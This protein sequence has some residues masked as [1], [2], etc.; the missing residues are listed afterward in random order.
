MFSG[1]K[2]LRRVFS[3]RG[4]FEPNHMKT[5]NK[6]RWRRVNFQLDLVPSDYLGLYCPHTF[7]MQVQR[8]LCRYA[9]LHGATGLYYK[10]YGT[11]GWARMIVHPFLSFQLMAL[12][13]FFPKYSYNPC[14]R[15]GYLHETLW[16]CVSGQEDVSRTITVTFLLFVSELCPFACVLCLFV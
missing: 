9:T 16:E 13:Y 6:M 3:W 2:S 1:C 7:S 12:W 4:S 10:R 14:N 5:F 11:V 15:L 8:W